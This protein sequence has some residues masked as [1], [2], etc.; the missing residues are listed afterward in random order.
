[1]KIITLLYGKA[2]QYQIIAMDIGNGFLSPIGKLTTKFTCPKNGSR[3]LTE[4]PTSRRFLGQG[5]MIC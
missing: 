3:N 2:V 4:Q 5:A 1:M